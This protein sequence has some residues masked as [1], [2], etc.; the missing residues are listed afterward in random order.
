V[1]A[2]WPEPAGSVLEELEARLR[3]LLGSNLRGMYVYGSLAFECYN[4][5]RSDVDVL[6]VTGRRMAPETR[7]AL[8]SFLR[9]LAETA[10]LEISFLSR[11][12]L[13]P[14]R[15]PCPFDYHFSAEDE[16]HDRADEYFATEIANARARGIALVGPPPAELLPAVPDDDFLDAVERDLIWARDRIAERPAYAV[17]N[18][19]RV[20]AFRRERTVMSKAQAGDWGARSVPEQY[21]SL[22]AGAAE[23]YAS[24]QDVELDREAVSSFVAWVAEAR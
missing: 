23:M 15:Y 11:A 13:D 7:R 8:S 6:V 17:L 14:W 12:D 21:R 3:D 5:A 2:R 24:P 16:A 1:S 20:L 9:R 19:C 10:P 18:A 4:P 22:V